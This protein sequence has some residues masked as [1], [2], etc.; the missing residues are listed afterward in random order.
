MRN[1]LLAMLFPLCAAFA[2][3]M[4]WSAEEM[5]LPNFDKGKW[6]KYIERAI[7][8]KA[9]LESKQLIGLT[10]DQVHTMFGTPFRPKLT[11]EFF[12]L[13]PIDHPRDVTACR[14]DGVRRAYNKNVLPCLKLEFENNKVKGVFLGTN[15]FGRL[16]EDAPIPD[17][18]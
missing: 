12:A 11:Q 14:F 10:S 7:T 13:E 3:G 8:A 6:D 15:D 18:N 1:M 4:A 9:L 2:P 5:P 17:S 16:P